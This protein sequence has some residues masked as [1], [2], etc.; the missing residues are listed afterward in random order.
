[1]SGHVYVL[2]A[3][4]GLCCTLSLSVTHTHTVGRNPLDERSALGRDL[5]LTTRNSHNRQT[6]MPPTGFEPAIPASERPQTDGLDR[7]ATGA[8]IINEC[9]G[10]LWICWLNSA[11]VYCKASTGTQTHNTKNCTNTQTQN[12]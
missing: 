1:M 3:V 2:A 9:S 8:G 10:Y 12:T 5:Y 11:S 4:D 7:A 6:S